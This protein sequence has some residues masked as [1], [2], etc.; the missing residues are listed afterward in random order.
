MHEDILETIKAYLQAV[1][2]QDFDACYELFDK[3][4]TAQYKRIIQ[5]F[6][7]KLYPFG[8]ADDFLRNLNVESLE[9]MKSFTDKEFLIGVLKGIARE[10]GEEDL[11]KIIESTEILGVDATDYLTIVTYKNRFPFFDEWMDMQSQ[12]SLIYKENR[13]QIIF[14]AGMETVFARFEREIDQYYQKKSLDQLSKVG[15]GNSLISYVLHGYKNGAGE[16]VF[17]ARFKDAGEFSEGLAYAKVFEKYGYIDL[18]GDFAIK[19]AF[20]EARDFEDGLAIVARR[21][22]EWNLQ[23][24]LIDPQGKVVVPLQ[25][26]EMRWFEEGF[27]AVQKDEEFWSFIDIQGNLLTA[28]TFL[29]VDSFSEGLCAVQ[30]ED[31]LWGYLDTEGKL[32]IPFTYV[33]AASFED[34]EAEVT[35]EKEDGAFIYIRIDQEGNWLD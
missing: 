15:T 13:W 18:K 2:E 32:R 22:E 8:E 21:D 19:P 33:H 20:D 35:F 23:W 3:E 25:F 12:I 26:S 30:N 7:E 6:A 24:G 1:Y 14:K 34:G 28:F 29:E 31:D 4:E 16:V 27:C 5:E 17:E 10:I 11:K 9:Q